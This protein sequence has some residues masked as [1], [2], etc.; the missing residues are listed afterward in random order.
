MCVA[1]VDGATESAH[2]GRDFGADREFP[3]GAGIDDADALYAAYFCGL[4]P[5]APTHV[6][7]RV[8]DAESLDPDH[9]F[10]LFGQ[11]LGDLGVGQSLQS[12]EAVEHNRAHGRAARGF[13]HH[14]GVSR[15]C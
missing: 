9:H 11:R 6:H 4:G 2:Q 3:S 5:F 7:F 14:R 15:D 12:P 1:A 8:V 13:S 10:T